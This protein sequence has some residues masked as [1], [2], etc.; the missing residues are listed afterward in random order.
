MSSI[1]YSV[2]ALSDRAPCKGSWRRM[3]EGKSK[4]DGRKLKKIALSGSQRG[5]TDS[6]HTYIELHTHSLPC[7][8][9][10]RPICN[11]S[12]CQAHTTYKVATSRGSSGGDEPMRSMLEIH[13]GKPESKLRITIICRMQIVLRS[14]PADRS[15]VD[16]SCC[17]RHVLDPPMI[18]TVETLVSSGK[19]DAAFPT[20]SHT[21]R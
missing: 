11:E 3:T 9:G 21:A 10:S 6:N 19:Q 12:K 14:Q 5:I 20:T 16:G 1:E 17:E 4:T 2:A 18:N 15:M 8:F 7:K 13:A